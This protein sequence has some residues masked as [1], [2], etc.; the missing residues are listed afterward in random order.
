MSRASLLLSDG[1]SVELVNGLKRVKCSRLDS[2]PRWFD[3]LPAVLFRC[4]DKCFLS[5]GS[6]GDCWRRPGTAAGDEDAVDR[7]GCPMGEEPEEVPV[8][9]M[10][11]GGLRATRVDMIGRAPVYTETMWQV[12]LLLR[13]GSDVGGDDEWGRDGI[14]VGR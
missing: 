2:G 9:D 13:V 1:E 3:S 4:G 6:V 11:T 5:L 7:R 8:Q 14:A 12:A 10:L